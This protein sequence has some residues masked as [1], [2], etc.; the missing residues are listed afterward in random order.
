MAPSQVSAAGSLPA[1]SAVKRATSRSLMAISELGLVWP[2]R[3]EV[4]YEYLR[5]NLWWTARGYKHIMDS[6]L[7]L[8]AGLQTMRYP[9]EPLGRSA[10]S[11]LAIALNTRDDARLLAHDVAIEALAER[12]LTHDL[13]GRALA[14]ML[15]WPDSPPERLGPALQPIA[16]AR[17]HDIQR[18][19]EAML[20]ALGERRP[21]RSTPGRIPVAL[22]RA[23]G[24]GVSGPAFGRVR[25]TT[26]SS[27]RPRD[28]QRTRCLTGNSWHSWSRR[29]LDSSQTAH[30]RAPLIVSDA[31]DA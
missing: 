30:A 23:G 10:T 13:L 6:R 20:S 22:R 21:S 4:Y 29:A 19:L 15:D 8:A 25:A 9:G 12:R 2:A 3:R 28:A 16:D 26:A 27:W 11:L 18:T 5:R 14:D 24:H 1:T 31:P 17:P 7:D